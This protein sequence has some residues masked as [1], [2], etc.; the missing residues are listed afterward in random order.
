MSKRA[1]IPLGVVAVTVAVTPAHLCGGARGVRRIL[2]RS[3][4]NGTINIPRHR[5]NACSNDITISSTN[6]SSMISLIC[7]MNLHRVSAFTIVV[8]C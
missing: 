8:P 1:R 4:A 6:R 3:P 7:C 5:K 2:I